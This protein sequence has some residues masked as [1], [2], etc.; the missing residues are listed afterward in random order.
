MPTLFA[1]TTESVAAVLANRE[2]LLRRYKLVFFTFG[3]DWICALLAIGKLSIVRDWV[4]RLGMFLRLCGPL[5]PFPRTVT[6]CLVGLE[7]IFPFEESVAI[8]S[9]LAQ[10]YLK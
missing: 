5:A 1:D 2:S 10:G 9:F 8:H 4:L 6:R 3:V 7:F